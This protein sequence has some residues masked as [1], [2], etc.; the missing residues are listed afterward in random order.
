MKKKVLVSVVLLSFFCSC[1]FESPGINTYTFFELAPL[2]IKITN[3]EIIEVIYPFIDLSI[4]LY[5]ELLKSGEI[6]ID[7][8]VSR[9]SDEPSKLNEQLISITTEHNIQ[10]WQI[11]T[12]EDGF[13][14][15]GSSFE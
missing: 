14:F 11:K 10:E 5:S 8:I 15:V 1:E 2:G 13:T 7:K 6:T 4:N 12:I 9:Y 3:G